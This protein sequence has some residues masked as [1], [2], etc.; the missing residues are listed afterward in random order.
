MTPAIPDL[1]SFI[2]KN[3]DKLRIT[4]YEK[5]SEKEIAYFE[6]IKTFLPDDV[7]LF[8]QFC[9]GFCSGKDLFRIIPLE[10]IIDPLLDDTNNKHVFNIAEYMIYCDTWQLQINPSNKND[11]MIYNEAEDVVILTNSFAEFLDRFL[12]G[13]VFDGLYDWREQ[14]KTR[15]NNR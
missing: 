12:T 2:Q 14:I 13:G 1:I 4:L 11:Y 9:N 3:K 10:E 7:K 15:L 5:A 6:S 8:Y